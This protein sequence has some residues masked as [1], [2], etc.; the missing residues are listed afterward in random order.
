MITLIGKLTSGALGWAMPGFG[1]WLA[2]GLAGTMA[3]AL[4]VGFGY[5]RGAEGKSAAVVAERAACE[6][7]I[8]KNAAASAEAMAKLMQD[9]RDGDDKEPAPKSK[10]DAAAA[11]K[12][13]NMCRENRS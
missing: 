6:V 4:M 2:Y 12:R 3:V 11:C 8:S 1:P 13:S 9:I 5:T 10:A 7:Q